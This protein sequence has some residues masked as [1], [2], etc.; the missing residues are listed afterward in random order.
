M[1]IQW[2]IVQKI[3]LGS[4]SNSSYQLLYYWMLQVLEMLLINLPFLVDMY[5]IYIT[6][7]NFFCVCLMLMPEKHSDASFSTGPRDYI[8]GSENHS[9]CF[10]SSNSKL[11]LEDICTAW[12]FSWSVW[13]SN[14]GTLLRNIFDTPNL[15]SIKYFRIRYF[16]TEHEVMIV[17]NKYPSV[18][19][20]FSFHKIDNDWPKFSYL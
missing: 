3:A 9:H 17:Q 4:E 14:L 19:L 6:C 20:P 16:M 1:Y 2:K 12:L 8:R 18:F 5:P 7:M 10:I 15:N 11:V 13:S